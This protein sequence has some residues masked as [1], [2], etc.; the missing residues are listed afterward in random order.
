MIDSEIRIGKE[1]SPEPVFSLSSIP[2]SALQCAE[3]FT[4]N[5]IR[6]SEHDKTISS[7]GCLLQKD[8][9]TT[10]S[11]LR[12]S[13][14]D[15]SRNGR[16]IGALIH[17]QKIANNSTGKWITLLSKAIFDNLCLKSI[18]IRTLRKWNIASLIQLLQL[19]IETKK[20]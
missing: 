1:G 5:K 14:E 19:S 20:A 8:D 9:S 13:R 18:Q 6:K 2:Y 11:V 10:C 17:K 15:L 12:E 7:F 4:T 16:L 3:R